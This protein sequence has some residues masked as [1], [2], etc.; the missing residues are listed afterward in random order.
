MDII[1]IINNGGSA[2]FVNAASECDN[3]RL[4]EAL[5]NAAKYADKQFCDTPDAYHAFREV[6][7][8]ADGDHGEIAALCENTA[9]AIV[10]RDEI[11]KVSFVAYLKARVMVF[12]SMDLLYTALGDAKKAGWARIGRDRSTSVSAA[13]EKFNSSEEH[14]ADWMDA[15]AELS[16]H[17]PAFEKWT[18]AARLSSRIQ[19]LHKRL[20]EITSPNLDYFDTFAELDAAKAEM[21][22][23]SDDERAGFKKGARLLQAVAT[24]MRKHQ[25]AAKNTAEWY[26]LAADFEAARAEA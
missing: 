17:Y 11:Q 3:A 14:S 19:K 25:A 1:R 6:F 2:D 15:F 18:S 23:I 20:S 7:L 4:A 10:F 8:A 5:R 12:T 22:H 24:A 21:P 26:N 13:L 16:A 9:E